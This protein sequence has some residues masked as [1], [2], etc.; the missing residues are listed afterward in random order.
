MPSVHPKFGEF[1]GMRTAASPQAYLLLEEGMHSDLLLDK[2]M[3]SAH[4]FRASTTMC[5]N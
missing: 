5:I 3:H 4:F 1:L 2:G